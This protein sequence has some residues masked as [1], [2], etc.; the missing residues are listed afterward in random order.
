MK[1]IL[2]GIVLALCLVACSESNVTVSGGGGT[3]G[4]CTNNNPINSGNSDTPP[5]VPAAGA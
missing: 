5:V 2:L 4:S 1:G 3:G